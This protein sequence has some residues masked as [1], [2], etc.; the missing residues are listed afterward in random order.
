[1]LY[2]RIIFAL[3]FLFSPNVSAM[4]P[5]VEDHTEKILSLRNFYFSDGDDERIETI[6]QQSKAELHQVLKKELLAKKLSNQQQA[7]QQNYDYFIKMAHSMNCA[8]KQSYI[9]EATKV[10]IISPKIILDQSISHGMFIPDPSGYIQ[11][12]LTIKF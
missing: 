10:A 1:M 2:M 9:G 12:W 4:D 6:L 7:N 8:M 3:S 11:S 5:S